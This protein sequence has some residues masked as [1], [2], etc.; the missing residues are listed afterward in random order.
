MGEVHAGKFIKFLDT[1]GFSIC[2]NMS[3]YT[4]IIR[5]IIQ[6]FTAKYKLLS[7]GKDM[8]LFFSE[9]H[10]LAYIRFITDYNAL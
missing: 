9:V 10:V 6:I 8:L 2:L 7:C 4:K 5:K 3:D 1:L